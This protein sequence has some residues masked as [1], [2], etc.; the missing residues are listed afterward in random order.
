MA[1]HNLIEKWFVVAQKVTLQN[2]SRVDLWAA[3]EVLTCRAFS[4]FQFTSNAKYR[5]VATIEWLQLSS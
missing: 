3:H 4:S 2:D 5:M 1:Q